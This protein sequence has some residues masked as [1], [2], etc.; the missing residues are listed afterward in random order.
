[1]GCSW[2]SHYWNFISNL[3]VFCAMFLPRS[4]M[5]LVMQLVLVDILF[6]VLLKILF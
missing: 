2:L 3:D 1:M 4:F 6:M 5:V